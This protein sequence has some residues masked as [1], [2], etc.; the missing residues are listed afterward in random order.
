MDN[1]GSHRRADDVS[2]TIKFFGPCEVWRQGVLIASTAWLQ[3]K[4]LALFKRMASARGRVFTQD[5]LI[6]ALFPEAKP[7]TATQ[8]LYRRLSELR[9]ILEPR[10]K[11]GSASKFILNV[12]SQSYCFS[13]KVPCE[14]DTEKFE[15]HLGSAQAAEKTS[16][17]LQA[18]QEYQTAIELYRDDFLV[19]DLYEEWTIGPREHWRELYLTALLR[20]AD[21]HARLGHYTEAIASCRKLLKQE[22]MR[23]IAFYQKMLYHALAGETSAA[24]QTYQD[25]VKALRARLDEKPQPETEELARQIVEGKLPA[26]LRRRYPLAAMPTQ[27]NLSGQLPSF[28]GREREIAEIKG[29]LG[30]GAQHAAPLRVVTLTGIGGSGKTRLA[31]RVAM[32][33]VQE[34]THGVWWVELAS[35]TDSGLVAQAVASALGLH[36]E[37]GSSL[38]EIL[39]NYLRPR[40]LLLILDNCEHLITACAQLTEFLLNAA[41]QLKILATSREILGAAGETVWQVPPLLL[42]DP[43]QTS[44]KTLAQSDAV[45]LFMERA[46]AA[47]SDFALTEQNVSL[48]AQ[49]CQRLD[50]IPLALELAAARVKTLSIKQIASRL[51]DCLQLLTG[52]R[53]TAVPRHQTLRAAIDWSYNLLSSK[54]R[55]LWGR[56]SVF[57]GGCTLEAAEGICTDSQHVGARSPRPYKSSDIAPAE[58]LDLLTQLVDKSLVVAEERG[59]ATR[60][61]L[62]ETVRQYAQIRLFEAGDAEIARDR[63]L[64]FFL[65]L[66][67]QAESRLRGADLK[68][69]LDRLEMEHDNLRAA[70]EWGRTH[71]QNTESALRLAG[72]LGW[73]WEVRGYWDESRRW[74]EDILS[75]SKN[76][77]ASVRAKA[78]TAA[79][80][81]AW[82]RG[83]YSQAT[84]LSEKGLALSQKLK[85]KRG[86]ASALNVLGL[87]AHYRGEFARATKAYRESLALCRSLKDKRGIASTLNNLGRV[88][89]YQGQHAQAAKMLE[90]SL[91]LWRELGDAWGTAMVLLLLGEVALSQGEHERARA[92]LDEGL[93]LC[94]SV[95]DKRG[96]ALAL[97]ILGAIAHLQRDCER[98]TAMLEESLRLCREIGDK[99]GLALA[100]DILG[101]VSHLQGDPIRATA[102]LKES[103]ALRRDLGDKRGIADCVEDLALIDLTQDPERAAKLFGMAEGLRQS[104]GAPLLPYE[105]QEHDRNL[106]AVRAK[107]GEKTF[108]IFWKMGLAMPLEGVIRY[109]LSEE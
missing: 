51:D 36:A 63:H 91:R 87:V 33:L 11:K 57:A 54:E 41:P 75:Q 69:W 16:R 92:L 106:T 77:L 89:Y 40:E 99:R 35:L 80:G 78:L 103:L 101:V 34:F 60:Y 108:E 4:T 65:E 48:V 94:R 26:S 24:L 107:L 85:D 84:A 8:N 39:S 14:I 70:L 44:S 25:C 64:H 46:K 86:V 28:I 20:T 5:Q 43:R 100:L 7:D 55:Q 62:L 81:L 59:E 31:L 104:I 19:E 98:A 13:D 66:A 22:P 79:G 109:A 49:I 88:A 15:E 105:R 32:D 90:E 27:H 96:I 52:G 83:E 74:L 71:Q 53:R 30:V 2:F 12:G 47:R 29:L 1:V 61:R 95:G 72:A 58:I 23:E 18:L 37:P 73:F 10:L 50:G 21:C 56:L 76:V 102:V 3:Q 67:E 38:P 93:A 68:S 82:R 9:Y 42:P 17:W 45:R 6:E 97:N